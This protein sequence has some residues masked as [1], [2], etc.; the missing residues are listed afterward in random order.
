MSMKPT[1]PRRKNAKQSSARATSF[2]ATR[3]HHSSEAAEDYT[4][5]ISDLIEDHG[6]ARTCNIAEHLG[7]SHVTALRTMKRLQEEGF[8]RTNQHKPVELTP[9]GRK[10][11]LYAKERHKLLIEF[12]LYLGIPKDVAEIDVEGAE[13]H[14]SAASLKCIK[15]FLAARK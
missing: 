4:E 5:L 6:E 8:V 10:L 12:F 13:H 9:K 11:A 3:K 14:I 1:S 15:E 7:V 2:H